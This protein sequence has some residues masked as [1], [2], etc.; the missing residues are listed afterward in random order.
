MDT[1][2]TTTQQKKNVWITVL[3]YFS[4]LFL[5][6]VY[7]PHGWEKLTVTIDPQEYVD[8]GLEGD[9]LDFYLIWE[10]SGFIW[11]IGAAQLIGGLLLIPRRTYLFGSVWLLPVSIGMLFCHVYISHAMDF[12]VFDAIVLVFNLYL[13]FINYTGLKNTFFKAKDTWI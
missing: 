10:R 1:E 7:I 4:R 12:L 8:F 11:V 2:N 3:G 6:W 13:I 9:F 5:A